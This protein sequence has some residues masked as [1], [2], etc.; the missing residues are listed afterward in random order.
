MREGRA[1][2]ASGLHQLWPQMGL[3][4]ADLREQTAFIFDVLCLEEHMAKALEL[5]SKAVGAAALGPRE[6]LRLG[7]APVL[8]S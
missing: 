5:I 7:A 4:D 8:P 2:S 1:R 3:T 6:E